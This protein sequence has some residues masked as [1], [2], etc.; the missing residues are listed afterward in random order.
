MNGDKK[1]WLNLKS[2]VAISDFGGDERVLAETTINDA[3]ERVVSY[4]SSLFGSGKDSVNILAYLATQEGMRDGITKYFKEGEYFKGQILSQEEADDLN[5]ASSAEEES[6]TNKYNNAIKLQNKYGDDLFSDANMLNNIAALQNGGVASL[7]ARALNEYYNDGDYYFPTVLD[8][9][10]FQNSGNYANYL[11]GGS[12]S[13]EEANA[14]TNKEKMVKY[15]QYKKDSYNDYVLE[16]G[17]QAG[18]FESFA[19]TITEKMF[20]DVLL[21]Q[22]IIIKIRF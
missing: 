7:M 22:E 6:N 10:D 16:K 12:L 9:N 18:S 21:M 15:E 11:L 20:D 17:D 14:L 13:V 3:G 8:G 1:Q 19:T 4:N 5:F 2:K